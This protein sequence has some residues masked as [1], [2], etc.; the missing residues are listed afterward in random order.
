MQFNKL[1]LQGF[2]SFV[3]G[4]ELE[5]AQG[6]T[7]V[8]GPN[9]CGKSNLV[10]GLRWVMGETSAKQ[11]RG[12]GMDDIIFGG[13][14]D[15][16]ARNVAEVVLS[17]D[18]SDRSAPSQFNDGEDLEVSRRI[19]REKG[20]TYRVNGQEVRARDVQILFADQATGPR[21]TALVSQGRVGAVISAKPTD[22]RLLLE[23]AA[24][25]TG[26]HSRRHEAELRLRAAETNLERLEDV[27]ITLDA[28][29]TALKKQARQAKRYRN[30]SHDIRKT[31]SIVLHHRWAAATGEVASAKAV[32]G[33]A[34]TAVAEETSVVGQATVKREALAEA[35]AP[36]RDA[37]VGAAAELQR[38]TMA[39]N[40]LDAEEKRV[41]AAIEQWTTRR[42]QIA[43]DLAREQGL[44]AEA[45][46]A[47]ARL[48]GERSEIERACSGETELIEAANTALD[49]A[50][51]RTT[52]I[53]TELAT[54][55]EQVAIGDAQL[56]AI[57]RELSD[58][59]ARA[60]RRR[61][62]HVTAVEERDALAAEGI[63]PAVLAEAEAAVAAI[64]A[65]L[66]DA[67][68]ELD[69]AEQA[70][71]DADNQRE[72]ARE[73][74]AAKE[75][76]RSR[77]RAEAAALQDLLAS[78]SDDEGAW[79]P[80]IS[81]I[82]V[83]PGYEAALGAAL[84]DDL[85][86]STDEAAPRHWRRLPILSDEPKLPEGARPLVGL[87]SN[88][89]P[90]A[91]SLSQ[92]G[93][94]EDAEAGVR[95]ANELK[96][97]QRLVDL[98]GNLWR[99]DGFVA[100]AETRSTASARLKQ[101]NRLAELE[102]RLPEADSDFEQADH[103]NDQI[104]ATAT[105]AADDE[106]GARDKVRQLDGDVAKARSRHSELAQDM[107]AKQARLESLHGSVAHLESEMGEIAGSIDAAQ[108]RRATIGDLDTLRDD[109]AVTRVRLSEARM[110]FQAAQIDHTRLV[111]EAEE[112][113]RRITAIAAD[114]ASW[115]ARRNGAAERVG[116]L[117]TRDTGA[118]GE[119]EAL[120][121][122][123]QE[124][125]AQRN[126]LMDTLN[127]AD[128]ARRA[129]ADKV[130]VAEGEL[131]EA[132]KILRAAEARLTETRED[133]VRAEAAVAQAGQTLEVVSER[134]AE[135]LECAPAKVLE[136]AEIPEGRDIPDLEAAEKRFERL[137]RERDNMGPVNLR[138]EQEADELAE[139]IA[140]VESERDDL[141]SAIARLRQGI[142]NL[143]R[144][145]RQRLVKSFEDVNKH[146]QELFVRI[147]GGGAAHLALT[148]ADDPL[149]AGLEI[150]ASPP[151]KKLQNLS[152]LSGGEQTMTA[153]ALLFAVFLTNP[154][155]ICV[156]DEVD[157]ALDDANVDRFCTMLSEI[158]GAS[159]TRFLVVTHHRM[160]MSRMDRLYG[161]TMP[162]QGV[163]Q[164]VS[165]DLRQAE[166]IR[167]TA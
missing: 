48:N 66:A 31:E 93:V 89:A 105:A 96:T 122:R 136:L 14:A 19:E 22:R 142:S 137:L 124:I 47:L 156:L 140:T 94:V 39:R 53:E 147:F 163:S 17:L 91:R 43:A 64:E 78:D 128:A 77:L 153:I 150:F 161:V 151:G 87:V 135:R 55:A 79:T 108:Q 6:L 75:E 69:T 164:L 61:Q 165:V 138:A 28:Q 58:L 83:T 101:R 30:I 34:E 60:N 158:A 154:A 12:A 114:E 148:E 49:K 68:R 71:S 110:A 120:A 10:E 106:R 118:A 76:V 46:A 15:R 155:P 3:D 145:A 73:R 167:A 50:R 129:A 45:E 5:I 21:S 37:E 51:D 81:H 113:Q 29:L 104:T 127:E 88:A 134:I 107:N 41:R 133:K 117:Q 42:D 115:D 109:V 160:T 119:L 97:G 38:L 121:A 111:R 116:E 20:S 103:A 40:E 157:A 159:D 63:D 86:A 141:I 13:T 123:P 2:K 125:E 67:R 8:V 56:A 126:S 146:F 26:L 9:G 33:E 65:Q 32:L 162:E 80:V 24:G 25:I 132:E 143:N 100:R 90:L 18:N 130:A 95:L 44:S 57:D 36:L 144:E 16:P 7:G 72:A 152:L 70:R 139:K 52:E 62:Q 11:M 98:D 4:T 112:R 99:W 85:D 35:V 166:S 82:D 131:A 149:Q 54:F 102:A 59:A 23:E 1:K 84:G 74:R 92:V 27:L